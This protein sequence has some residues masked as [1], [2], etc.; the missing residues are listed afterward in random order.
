MAD[1]SR[2]SLL[3][4]AGVLC[5]LGAALAT[6]GFWLIGGRQGILLIVARMRRTTP[7]ANQPVAWDPGPSEAPAARKPNIIVI[8][9]DDMGF[10]D[11]TF[12]GGGVAGGAVPTPQIN[13]IGRD[14]V[15]FPMAYAGNATCSSSRAA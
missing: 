1:H 12:N 5:L 15:H 13:S 2:R 11:I 7:A 6:A 4:K 10:N 9:A 3:L 14:G 8:L